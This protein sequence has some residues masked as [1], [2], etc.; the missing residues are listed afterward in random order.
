MQ[1]PAPGRLERGRGPQSAGKPRAPASSA[2]PNPERLPTALAASPRE[3]ASV[4]VSAARGPLLSRLL[5]LRPLALC[6]VVEGR[7]HSG[8]DRQL[9]VSLS[10]A[11]SPLSTSLG[12]N[13]DV[14]N[15]GRQLGFHQTVANSS[16]KW[17]SL[18]QKTRF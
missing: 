1:P 18:E 11:L 13:S 9:L 12:G 6:A 4:F 15:H 3:V 14:I 8:S 7:R 5:H 16:R 2:A 10:R 17:V